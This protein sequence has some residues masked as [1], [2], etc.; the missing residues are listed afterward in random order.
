MS[1]LNSVSGHGAGEPLPRQLLGTL[2]LQVS[3]NPE[4]AGV[5]LQDKTQKAFV[6]DAADIKANKYDLSINRYKEVV[7]EE[8]VYEAPKVILKKLKDLEKE[9]LQDLDE[10]EAML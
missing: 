7:Y 5:F 4:N 8:E 6:V 2:G 9:I 10:L 1:S 3:A